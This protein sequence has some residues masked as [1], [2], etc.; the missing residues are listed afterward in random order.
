MHQV[1]YD[2][3]ILFIL[4]SSRKVERNS[5]ISIKIL[6]SLTSKT[7]KIIISEEMSMCKKEIIVINVPSLIP[8]PPE[9]PGVMKPI[10]HD[11]I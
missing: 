9:A 2:E 4:D 10:S 11:I 5:S 6:I 3:C 8:N 7:E 1:P